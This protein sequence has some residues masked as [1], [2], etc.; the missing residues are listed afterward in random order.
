MGV[1]TYSMKFPDI[2]V[3]FNPEN[4]DKGWDV[5]LKQGYGLFTDYYF[6][7]TQDEWFLGA[8]LAIQ[9]Y[10]IKN[11][12]TGSDHQDF[13]NFLIMPYVGYRWFPAD[14]GIY[15]Q[16]WMGIGYTEQISG[17]TQL[18]DNNYDVSPIIPYLAVHIGYRF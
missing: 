17:S 2:L 12:D 18:G 15:I 9:E 3:D 16:P 5:Q 11:S 6:N 8:Q 10:R 7:S 1:G 13:T 4:A 14:D